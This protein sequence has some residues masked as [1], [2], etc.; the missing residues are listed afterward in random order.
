MNE[1]PLKVRVGGVPEHFNLPWHLA[2]EDGAFTSLGVDVEYE[3]YPGGTGAMN[4]ALNTGD[5]D[6]ALLLT[7]GAVLDILKG[8]DNRMVKVY[9][10][11]PLTW[12]IHVA[13]QGDIKSI[14][15]IEDRSVA[16][17]RYGSGSHLIAIV[18]AMERGFAPERMR[19]VVVDS[20]AGAREALPEG[21]ADVFLWE[22]H[23]TQPFV[24]AGEF[25][26]VGERVVPWPAFVVSAR[27]RFLEQHGA[28]VRSVLDTV[29]RYASRLLND[30][31][32]PGLVSS[33][34]G[35]SIADAEAW[36]ASVSLHGD[37]DSPDSAFERI[38]EA[39][40]LGGV[41]DGSS[42]DQ[43]LWYELP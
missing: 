32:A 21:R 27:R 7:E 36:L 39:L 37:Y 14:G 34:F 19:F 29:D 4:A 38:I 28:L 16:I 17:S 10:D 31:D 11:S 12:G 20:L 41:F 25:R 18:D 33:R 13:A 23:M 40:R 42:S 26:R 24:D 35:I 30:P 1:P 43:E 9:V 2:I 5:L 6:L 15:G 22:K 8:S 3:D